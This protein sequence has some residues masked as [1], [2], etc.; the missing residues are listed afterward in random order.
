LVNVPSCAFARQCSE[1]ED[2]VST[3]K[4]DSAHFISH[5]SFYYNSLVSGVRFNAESG[6]TGKPHE[7]NHVIFDR[8]FCSQ[9]LCQARRNIMK[10]EGLVV[11]R[12]E[13]FN[14]RFGRVV[15]LLYDAVLDETKWGEVAPEI[16][17]AFASTSSVLKTYGGA[18]DPQLASV[19]DNLRVSTRDQSWADHWH[20]H[21]LWVERATQ[22]DRGFVFTSQSLIPDAQFERTGFYQDWTRKLDI[23]HMVGVLFPVG[24]DKTGVLGVHRARTAGRF[25]EADRDRLRSLFP[26]VRRALDLRERLRPT[27]LV[28]EAAMDALER[29]DTGVLVVNASCVM[30]YANEAA[31][32]LLKSSKEIRAHMQCFCIDDPALNNRLARLVREAVWTSAGKPHTPAA[33]LAVPRQGQ[34]P[35][36][37]L[38]APWRSSWTNASA[39]QPAASIFIRDPEASGPGA[40]QTLRELF[41][42]TCAEAAIAVAIGEGQSV[43]Q[44]AAT[45]CV[46]LGTVRTHLKKALVKTGTNRQGALASL[47][48]RCVAGISPHP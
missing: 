31:E 24:R 21:D 17:D 25:V 23:Y 41:G 44:I 35:V 34:L 9:A 36:T 8:A 2:C 40:Q 22:L 4:P 27:A 13:R 29:I 47:V 3:A 43:D 11:R 46:G 10:S 28:Q 12:N 38:V 32:R 5:A 39:A 45:L 30:L 37:L 16:A 18:H 6:R 19:T 20:Q 33:V 14:E 42:L 15:D 26:H 48:A 7:I 1:I